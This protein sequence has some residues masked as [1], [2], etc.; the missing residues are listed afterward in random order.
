[1][2]SIQVDGI[3]YR[4]FDHLYAVSRCGKVLRK[5][6]P[7]TPTQHNMGYLCLGR[8][9]LMHRAVAICWVPNP[10][11]RPY[12]HH[13]N[14]DKTDNRA[15]NLEWVTPKEHLAERHEGLGGHYVRTEET[16]AK[17][18]AFR[19]GS[20]MPE[21]VKEKIR[22]SSIGKSHIYPTERKPYSD[23][24]RKQ[25]SENHARNTECKILG[26]TYRSFTEAATAL[27]VNKMTL[28]QRCLSKNFPD[29][30]IISKN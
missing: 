20:K 24:S 10:G 2:I 23:E 1:M 3:E 17:L 6:Q 21:E 26:V 29:Y 28:R 30:Q 5:L 4:F 14:H 22:A 12:V 9:R 25:R 27:G 8:Q 16:R 18:R 15:E 7:Y 19:L 11:N 13:I